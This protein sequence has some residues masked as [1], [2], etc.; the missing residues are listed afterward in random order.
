MPLDPQMQGLLQAIRQA[1]LPEIGSV[2]AAVLRSLLRGPAPAA[3]A[4][5]SVIDASIAG[6]AGDIPVRVYRPMEVTAGLIVYCHGGGWTVGD[7]DSHDGMV[8]LMANL[9]GCTIVSVD[10]RLAPEH[11]FPAAIEDA[12][13]AAGWA[14]RERHAL[15]G[16]AQAPL[17]LMGDSAGANLAAVVSILARDAGGPDIAL[18]V[19]LY[20]STEGDL[21]SDRMR[22]F[23]PPFMSREEISWFYDQYIPV[24]RRGDFRF[25]PG[26][27]ADLSRLPPAVIVTAEYDLLAEEG[28]L[29]GRKLLAAGTDVT[30][31]HYG[32]VIHGFMSMDLSLGASRRAI[33]DVVE[34]IAAV[35]AG[36]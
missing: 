11:P 6:P 32:G 27:T 18:Q 3:A 35:T 4:V 24:H 28:L 14:D 15:T 17:I 20:P 23:E 12:W 16:R 7:L 26:K 21:E 1:G 31:L 9:T 8:R 13:A 22:R 29:Y 19:L 10:Y 36:V 25:A 2:S 33:S 30:P 5:G 34:R